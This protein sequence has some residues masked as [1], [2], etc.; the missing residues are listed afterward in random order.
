MMAVERKSYVHHYYYSSCGGHE[1]VYQ[2]IYFLY[3]HFMFYILLKA[4]SDD[5][6]CGALEN[7]SYG[8]N[9]KF[10]ILG[11]LAQI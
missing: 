1:C 7:V 5:P 11:K 6:H 3:F 10:L 9:I 8:R 4:R 2:I